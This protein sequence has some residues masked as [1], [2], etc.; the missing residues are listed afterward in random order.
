MAGLSAL[1]AFDSAKLSPLLL[2][3]TCDMALKFHPALGTI[4][5]CDF[6]GLN[7]P[8]MTKKRP[9][10]VVSPRFRCR[11]RLC[12]IIPF[13]TTAPRPV[14]LYHYKLTMAPVL[15]EPYD[16]E[17]QWVKADMLYTMAFDRLSLPFCGKDDAGKRLYDD[18]VLDPVDFKA[19]QAALLHGIGLGRLTKAL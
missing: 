13:S 8:E 10:V 1:W 5:I 4:V 15:P 18:R 2:L 11:D 14:E 17:I 9:A 7:N 6:N 16:S 12:T 3:V 19:I